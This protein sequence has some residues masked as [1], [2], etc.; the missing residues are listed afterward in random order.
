MGRVSVAF[1]LTGENMGVAT[2]EDAKLVIYC[3]IVD[4]ECLYCEMRKECCKFKEKFG[5]F[6][7]SANLVK[8]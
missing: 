6:P 8:L 4:P 1:Y 2:I 3:N 5:I 7:A